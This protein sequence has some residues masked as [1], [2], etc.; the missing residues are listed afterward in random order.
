MNKIILLLICLMMV[1]RCALAASPPVPT[2][3]DVAYGPSPRQVLDV[4]VPTNGAGP[5]PVLLW[6]GGLWKPAK[7]APD[8]N[9][10]LPHGVAVV[11]VQLR[12]MS[13]AVE[14]KER[15]PVSYV[16]ND[17]CRAVQF[18]RLNAAR[19]QLDGQRIAVGGGSQGA[20]PALYVGCSGDRANAQATDAVERV[21]TRVTCVAAYRSQ[22]SIDPQR[23]QKWVPGVM[24]G[25]PALGCAFEESLKRR[26][27]LLPLIKQWS[28]D[29]L[30][31]RGAAPIYFENN[32]D[33]TRPAD[34]KE[35]DYK[36]HAPA[37]G[38]GFQ[39]LAQQA[40]ATCL[41]KYPEHPTEGY[42][43][44]WD[45]IVKQLKTAATPQ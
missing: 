3:A 33:L 34:V 20:L 8:L 31:H 24:W 16:M 23:M 45:F 11:A 5:F 12:T 6:Y 10:F 14:A 7:H 43:D 18:V 42:T 38:L 30:L 28:P 17:A 35:M 22:P 2:V 39:K 26:A 37:W 15:A 27:E 1:S 40:G 32:W 21:T 36:V 44:I 29:W 19:W 9:H 25:A 13:D 4:F 41:V